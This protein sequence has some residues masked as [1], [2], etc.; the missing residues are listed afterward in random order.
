[1]LEIDGAELSAHPDL[2]RQMFEMIVG[3]VERHQARQLA[4]RGWQISGEKNYS[5]LLKQF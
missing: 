1:V 4:Y 5:L 2:L 3:H